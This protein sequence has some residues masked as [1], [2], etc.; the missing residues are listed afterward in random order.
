[1]TIYVLGAGPTALA[2]VDG[3]TE[4]TDEKTVLIE[5][6]NDVGGLAKTVK[7]KNYG[8]HDLGPHKLY[9]QDEKLLNRVR[10]HLESDLWLKRE[11]VSK[12]FINDVYLNYPPSILSLPKVFGINVFLRMVV[13]FLLS[14]VNLI[15]FGRRPRSFED[16]L[17]QRVGNTLYRSIFFPIA[18]KLWGKPSEL[19]VKLSRGRVQVPSLREIILNIL[20]IRRKS[21]FEALHFFYPRGGLQVLWQAILKKSRSQCRLLL[22]HRITDIKMKNGLVQSLVCQT[23]DELKEFKI[24]ENDF[25]ISTLPVKYSL[26]LLKNNLPKKLTN[27]SRSLIQLNDLILVFFYIDR[28]ELLEE[29]WV[30]IPEE[31]YIFHRI[32]EQNSFD[33][34]M[35]KKGSIVCCEVLVKDKTEQK[36]WS[37]QMFV[38][39]VENDLKELKLKN[40]K[41]LDTKVIRL[42]NSYPV[43]KTGYE[44]VINSTLK[45]LDTFDNFKSIGRQ[46]AFNYIGTLDSMDIGYGTSKLVAARKSGGWEAERIRTSF[47]PVL[48]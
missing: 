35:I 29:S 43:L 15:N 34:H 48:D 41:I 26:E 27:K 9:T 8:S 21:K 12:I 24:H 20:N 31:K 6:S 23:E 22:G 2:T 11:K 5:A 32:S 45:T 44:E 17:K 46:G 36:N 13:D 1:M 16:D 42:K 18:S 47:Y 25:V 30:F 37:D 28:D 10:G 33:P 19:D 3:L 39:R 38:D 7:W 40:Y 14:K 4:L